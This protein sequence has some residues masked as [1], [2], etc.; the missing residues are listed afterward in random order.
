[1][2][3]NDMKPTLTHFRVNFFSCVYGDDILMFI[4]NKLLEIM[5]GLTYASECELLGLTFT[6][7]DKTSALVKV[8][9]IE[10]CQFLKR[11]FRF[12]AKLGYVCPLDIKSMEGTLNFVS[13]YD[14]V[15]ELTQIKIFNFQREARLHGLEYYDNVIK[16][17]TFYLVSNKLQYQLLSIGYIE[18][19]YMMDKD[20]FA[21]GLMWD[22]SLN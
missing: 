6:T 2:M 13:Q 12:D 8:K 17:L 5:N 10:D 1:M 15:D 18:D 7:A 9:G 3:K 19:L 14:R 4:R 11:S 16:N 22:R 21:E 20:A